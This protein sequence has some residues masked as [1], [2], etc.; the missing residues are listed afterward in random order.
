VKINVTAHLTEEISKK[1]LAAKA[2]LKGEGLSLPRRPVYDTPRL[3]LDITDLPDDSIMRLLVKF[4]RYQDHIAGK[5]YEAEIDEHSVETMLEVAKAHYITGNWTGASSDRVAIAKAEAVIDK[6]VRALDDELATCR[7]NRKAYTIL[8]D[9]LA[10]DASVVSREISRRIGNSNNEQ[11]SN[12][13]T[14]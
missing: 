11:R 4:T 1:A 5:V 13:Y 9:A 6:D 3:P 7:A 10:R 14:A 12:R 8:L 2:K